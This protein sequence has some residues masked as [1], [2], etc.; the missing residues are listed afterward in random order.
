MEVRGVETLLPPSLASPCPPPPPL[1]VTPDFVKAAAKA[2]L[3][4]AAGL[5][6]GSTPPEFEVP[7]P[8]PPRRAL[9]AAEGLPEADE[10][11][12]APATV[13]K[14]APKEGKTRSPKKPW[15]V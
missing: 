13:H 8:R 6:R 15:D 2:E 9:E 11:R 12:P 3:M 5:V 1:Q 7:P 10:R 4:T 14:V